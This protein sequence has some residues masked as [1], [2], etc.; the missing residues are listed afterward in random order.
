MEFEGSQH[1]VGVRDKGC[2]PDRQ[3][4]A[5]R[6]HPLEL[7][8]NNSGFTNVSLYKQIFTLCLYATFG[9]ASL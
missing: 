4:K 7:I 3:P 6:W 1:L 5:W 9:E 2:S 8:V